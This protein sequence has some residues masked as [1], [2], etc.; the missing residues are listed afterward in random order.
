MCPKEGNLHSTF[1]SLY[2]V[3]ETTYMIRWITIIVV[4]MLILEAVA[5][6]SAGDDDDPDGYA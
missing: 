1:D 3:S 2:V 4:A 6:A 5:M